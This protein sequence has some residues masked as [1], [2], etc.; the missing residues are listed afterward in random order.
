VVRILVGK[1][2]PPSV[3]LNA[4]VAANLS[5]HAGIS[6]QDVFIVLTPGI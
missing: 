3:K 6:A 2:P 1:E 5:Q 4:A